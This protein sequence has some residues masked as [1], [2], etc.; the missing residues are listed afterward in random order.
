MNSHRQFTETIGERI[1]W[2][3]IKGFSLESHNVWLKETLNKACCK[4]GSRSDKA[5]QWVLTVTSKP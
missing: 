3:T 1:R 2:T 5:S 4:S